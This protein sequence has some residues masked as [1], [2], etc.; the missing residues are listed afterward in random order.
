MPC[1]PSHIR[2]TERW[3][4]GRRRTPGKCVGGKPSPGFESL[5]LRHLPP[6]KHMYLCENLGA[7]VSRSPFYSP[8]RKS[9]RVWLPRPSA[10]FD[11]PSKTKP[12]IL[13]N[14]E[15]E[16]GHA[17][18]FGSVA[19]GCETVQARRFMST[20]G[21]NCSR[22]NGF[23][24]PMRRPFHLR[25]GCI[26]IYTAR[27][28]RRMRCHHVRRAVKFLTGCIRWLPAIFRSPIQGA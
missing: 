13:T 12:T 16:P 23:Q 27:L 4:S 25:Y 3:P 9:G 14:P 19:A 7:K 26:R 15:H 21:F 22:S 5:S 28:G 17:G 11:R 8:A 20:A 10:I 24:N 18:F 6:S 2:P 1:N